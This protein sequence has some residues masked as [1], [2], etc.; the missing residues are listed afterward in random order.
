MQPINHVCFMSNLS[1]WNDGKNFLLVFFLIHRNFQFTCNNIYYRSNMFI[2][3]YRHV[4]YDW[5]ISHKIKSDGDHTR[6]LNS[7]IIRIFLAPVLHACLICFCH[8]CK[9]YSRMLNASYYALASS[10]FLYEYFILHRQPKN[11]PSFI[12]FN[13]M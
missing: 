6:A 11:F 13:R 12:A 4:S 10:S 3:S 2:W 5:Q 8:Q 9:S 7:C 1:L